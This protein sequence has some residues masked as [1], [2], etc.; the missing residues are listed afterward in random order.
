MISNSP[1]VEVE[2]PVF[3]WSFQMPV[4]SSR[5]ALCSLQ[6]RVRSD[7]CNEAKGMK[8]PNFLYII[9]DQLRADHVGFGGNDIVQPTQ[10]AGATWLK[11][12]FVEED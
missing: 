6:F 10:G 2:I 12:E 3:P 4:R 11:R 8:Q 5:P 7:P 1:K 9:F